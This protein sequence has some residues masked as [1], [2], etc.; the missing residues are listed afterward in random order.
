[1]V[2]AK[3]PPRSYHPHVARHGTL[4]GLDREHDEHDDR[5]YDDTDLVVV[6]LDEAPPLWVR[7]DREA[8]DE[9]FAQ[10]AFGLGTVRRRLHADRASRA[11]MWVLL[12][13]VVAMLAALIGNPGQSTPGGSTADASRVL[14]APTGAQVVIVANDRI[15]NIDVDRRAE[16]VARL[17]GI[18]DGTATAVVSAGDTFAAV[19]R[20]RAWGVNR[21]LDRPAV[22]LGPAD[23]VFRSGSEGWVWVAVATSSGWELRM[24]STVSGARGAPYVTDTASGT[25]RPVGVI[26]PDGLVLDRIEN[27]QR[28]VGSSERSRPI[29]RRDAVLG[30]ADTSVVA[31]DCGGRTCTIVFTDLHSGREHRIRT[32]LPSDWSIGPSAVTLDNGAVAALASPPGSDSSRVLIAKDGMTR[33]VDVGGHATGLTWSPDW[34]FVMLDDGRLEAIGVAGGARTVDLPSL[35]NGALLAG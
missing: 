27:G 26:Q 24:V 23:V 6:E 8:F 19:V 7:T 4:V 21:N 18:P 16:R 17:A 5:R 9:Q 13:A 22:D 1:M 31:L 29:P 3:P 30:L 25:G 15:E 32:P 10:L 33:V 20:G 12:L 28:V 11:P 34:L 2:G 35:P 14:E